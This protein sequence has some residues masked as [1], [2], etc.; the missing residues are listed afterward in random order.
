M[1]SEKQIIAVIDFHGTLCERDCVR[2]LRELEGA[3]PVL[4]SAEAPR[5]PDGVAGIVIPGGFSYGDYI[6]PGAMART[7]SIVHALYEEAERGTPILGICN[8]FQIL[9]ELRLLPGILI[10]NRGGRFICRA[11]PLKIMTRRT[12]FLAQAERDV[13]T[14][15]IAH[16]YGQ[17]YASPETL[18]RLRAQDQIALCYCDETG[19]VTDAANPNGSAASIAGVTN[20][21][22]NVLGMM[23]H[24]ERRAM[25]WASGQDGLLLLQGVLATTTLTR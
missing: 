3:E 4:V 11:F 25:P 23:P 15:P 24:P 19:A 1:K 10:K 8:G 18:E 6:R 22:G 2:A 17:Y 14:L 16:K 20:E 5:L 21:A 9:C 12:P 7:A 13:L